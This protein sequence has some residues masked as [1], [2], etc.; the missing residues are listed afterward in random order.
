VTCI[1]KPRDR[2]VEMPIRRPRLDS[3]VISAPPTP[4][5]IVIALGPGIRPPSRGA[6][7]WVSRAR[8]YVPTPLD[9][10][11]A[12][13]PASGSVK[14]GGSVS[15]SHVLPSQKRTAKSRGP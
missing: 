13:G 9:M 6:P 4:L 15:A 14:R 1:A 12:M 5:V 2:P 11:L 8:S 3:S 7:L 10:T